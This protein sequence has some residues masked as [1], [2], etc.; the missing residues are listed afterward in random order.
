MLKNKNNF[1]SHSGF[2]IISFFYD[3]LNLAATQKK[4]KISFINFQS[5]AS[6]LSSLRS[7]SELSYSSRSL[8]FSS[9][10]NQAS[11]SIIGLWENCSK[12]LLSIE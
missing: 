5:P 10:P 6:K 4:K 11:V 1:S 3:H 12:V 8:S 7:A 9:F 2:I